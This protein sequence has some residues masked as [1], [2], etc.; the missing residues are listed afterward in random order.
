MRIY[1]C[2][3][4]YNWMEFV[5]LEPSG[6]NLCTYMLAFFCIYNMIVIES[7]VGRHFYVCMR[8]YHKPDGF[9]I[10]MCIYVYYLLEIVDLRASKEFSLV[11]R[12]YT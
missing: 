4:I 9:S 1:M 7:T 10:Y 11:L 2:V 5:L 3:C 8:V 6:N 12:V